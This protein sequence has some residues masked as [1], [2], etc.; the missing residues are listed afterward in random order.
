MIHRLARWLETAGC[1]LKN[2]SV[3][4]RHT[5]D[6][7]PMDIDELGPETATCDGCQATRDPGEMA[8]SFG[9]GADCEPTTL[10]LCALCA[11]RLQGDK[12]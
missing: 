9:R 2:L 7:P 4:L 1:L 12:N 10:M 3:I 5:G 11:P 6:G 8:I